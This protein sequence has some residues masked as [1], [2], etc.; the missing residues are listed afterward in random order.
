M[1]F[2][3]YTTGWVSARPANHLGLHLSMHVGYVF[4]KRE[5]QRREAEDNHDNR[6][7][8]DGFENR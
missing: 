5:I 1:T 4:I 6:Y 7:R 8:V 2:G 3:F